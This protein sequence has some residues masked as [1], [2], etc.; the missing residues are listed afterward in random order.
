MFCKVFTPLQVSPK[1]QSTTNQSRLLPEDCWLC[2]GFSS[3]QSLGRGLV[4]AA[5]KRKDH[6]IAGLKRDDLL[7]TPTFFCCFCVF[8]GAFL[9]DWKLGVFGLERG[10]SNE[11]RGS[12]TGG[13]LTA[14][15]LFVASRDVVLRRLSIQR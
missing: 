7:R 1:Y 14:S 10:V 6:Y 12:R 3:N 2:G 4:F 11:Q 5:N 9:K 13:Q 15:Y 8:W